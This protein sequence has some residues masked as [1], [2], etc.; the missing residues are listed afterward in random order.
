MEEDPSTAPESPE[1]HKGIGERPQLRV[2]P[3][4]EGTGGEEEG[5][6]Q[7]IGAVPRIQVEAWLW[8]QENR[9]EDGRLPSGKEIAARFGRKERWGRLIKQWG[10]QGRFDTVAV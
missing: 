8:A 10:Q 9:D 4:A 5:I 6:Q 2:V 1:E 7:G 3:A